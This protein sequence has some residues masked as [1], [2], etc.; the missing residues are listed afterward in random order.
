ME[1][2]KYV[3]AYR[4]KKTSV[5]FKAE[6]S[7]YEVNHDPS[8]AKP[9]DILCVKVPKPK[10]EIVIPGTIALTFNLDIA[11]PSTTYP[12][13]NLSANII[14]KIV[15]KIASEEVF[16]LDYAYLYNTYKD[17]WITEKQRNNS[18]FRGI[19][20]EEL[21]KMRADMAASPPNPKDTNVKLRNVYGKR[22]SIPL[23]F[24]LVRDHMPLPA[25]DLLDEI[26]FELTVSDKKFVLNYTKADAADFRMNDIR[27][28]YETLRH[29]KL[30]G[31]I[32]LELK[33]TYFLHDYVQQC[34]RT[35]IKKADTLVNHKV[36][37]SRQSLKGILLLFQDRFEEGKRD[38]EKF[39]NPDITN[40]KLT[41]EKPNEI[42]KTGYAVT[43]QWNEIIRHFMPEESKITHDAYMDVGKYYGGDKFG[44]WIDFRSTEDNS[45]H[46]SGR[47][48]R[49][50]IQIEITK[51][52]RGE[53]EYIMHTFI[54]ADA[55]IPI[56]DKKFG[57]LELY[58]K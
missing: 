54:V 6:R 8:T 18:V 49:E 35:I 14:S 27:L 51:K 5:H 43:E 47:K 39:P 58:A 15:V 28:R 4:S 25:S 55:R 31:D 29:E 11:E 50:P 19:Q 20:D 10:D 24:E 44:L 12:V 23:D 41:I 46:G 17:F 37:V 45:L 48:Q 56:V 7:I 22:Y 52:N 53:G 40:V 33:K 57:K 32:L 13:N 30:N 3:S 34:D 21:R 38:S 16:I 1:V 26:V 36:N 2:G 9:G 42:Y